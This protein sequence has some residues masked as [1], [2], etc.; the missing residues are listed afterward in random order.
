[1][2]RI[3]QI[4]SSILLGSA[5]FMFFHLLV[6]AGAVLA[7]AFGLAAALGGFLLLNPKKWD[8]EIAK[9]AQVYGITPDVIEKTI[10]KGGKKLR[11]MR[12]YAETI[13]K[14]SVR[15]SIERIGET[16]EKIF[17]NFKHDPKDIKAARQFL[18]YYLDSTIKIIRQY[19]MLSQKGGG[20]GNAETLK[21]AEEVL[22]TIEKA[23]E[24]QLATLY[25]DDFL[26]LD[27]EIS[28]LDKSMKMDGMG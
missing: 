16:A 7:S 2:K 15:K 25:D 1:M 17:Q 22:G 18:N 8:P 4:I 28:V 24:K 13:D 27:A 12:K 9:L 23:F 10:K 5:I 21:K 3:F 26:D 19:A 20:S 11:A 6:E 14:Q